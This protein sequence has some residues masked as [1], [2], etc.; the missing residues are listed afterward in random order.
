MH[1][2]WFYSNC[3]FS[4]VFFCFFFSTENHR[5]EV[6]GLWSDFPKIKLAVKVLIKDS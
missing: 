1:I 5:H 4:V 2:S 3:T 6:H